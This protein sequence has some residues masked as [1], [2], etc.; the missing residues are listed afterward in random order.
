MPDFDE[1]DIAI[2]RARRLI[3]GGRCVLSSDWSVARPSA[4]DEDALLEANSWEEYSAWHLG[5]DDGEQYDTRER[6]AFPTGDFRQVHRS[7]LVHALIHAERD[8]HMAVKRAAEDLLA[9]LAQV[10]GG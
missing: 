2:R 4:D 1:N 3:E 5:V 9:R 8:G 10:A 6:Y 7:A